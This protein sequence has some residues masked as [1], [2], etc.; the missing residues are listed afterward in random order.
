M[1]KVSKLLTD[2]YRQDPRFRDK[3][4][5]SIKNQ[6]SPLTKLQKGGK[7]VKLS[8]RAV[9]TILTLKNLEKNLKK[10]QKG[11]DKGKRLWYNTKAVARKRAAE[12]SLKI[13]QQREKYK[14]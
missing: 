2:F 12:R 3:S 10:F 14:A 7:I 5:K 9:A 1:G 6:K 8:A 11:I 13:E 4:N